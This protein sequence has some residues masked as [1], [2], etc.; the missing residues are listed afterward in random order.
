[1]FD[2]FSRWISDLDDKQGGIK[3]TKKMKMKRKGIKKNEKK[4]KM[5]ADRC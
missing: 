4:K 2:G 3:T 1:L 5:T